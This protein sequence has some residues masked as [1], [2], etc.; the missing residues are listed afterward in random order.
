MKN[1]CEN[2]SVE[3]EK[4][5]AKQKYVLVTVL[6]IN[7]LMFFL[8]FLFGVLSKS[9]ALLADSLDMLGDA[10]VYAF[11]LYVINKSVKWES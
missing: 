9:T 7:T 8:E 3:L 10:S 6:I 1:C 2:K 11:S 5:R 4:L